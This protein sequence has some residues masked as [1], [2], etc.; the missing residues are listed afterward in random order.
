MHFISVCFE[1]NPTEV[2]SNTWWIDSRATTHVSNTMQG[3]LTTRP[4]IQIRIFYSWEI[5]LKLKLKPLGL[6]VYF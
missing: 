6:I 3:F 5:G 4:Q 2:L 1:S